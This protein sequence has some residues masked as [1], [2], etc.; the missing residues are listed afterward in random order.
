MSATLEK[1]MEQY[2]DENREKYIERFI[3][4]NKLFTTKEVAKILRCS[5]N[6]IATWL[7]QE[8]FPKPVYFGRHKYWRARDVE[9][10]LEIGVKND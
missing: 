9:A 2:V 5:R 3:E 1:E 7:K 10:I 4:E 8:K 6:A